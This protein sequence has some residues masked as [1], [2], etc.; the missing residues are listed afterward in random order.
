M[1]IPFFDC[2]CDTAVEMLQKNEG[3]RKNG[4][5]VDL[6]RLSAFSP[7]AQVFAVCTCKSDHSEADAAIIKLKDEITKNS[8]LISLCLSFEDIESAEK[9]HKT[10][11]LLSIEGGEQYGCSI[12]G[13]YEMGVRIIHPTWNYDNALSGAAMG[14]GSGL[15]EQGRE[16]IKKAQSIGILID[17]SHISERGFWDTLEISQSPVIA[18]H[19]DSAAVCNAPRNL[20]DAQFTAL[21]RQCGGAGI[22]LYP[23]FL[24]LNTDID[25]V[26]A[27]IEHFLSLGGEKSVFLGC[28]FDGIECTPEGISGVQDIEKLYDALLKRNYPEALVRDIFRNNIYEIMRKVL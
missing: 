4:L 10:A 25:A 27:H 26:V 7:S 19:S 9:A 21:V 6:E 17:L 14:S 15:T 8:D 23:H 12:D 5:H 2:H 3:L 18:G 13:L 24:G 11:A 16:Y 20:T 1:K 22:N 28:D